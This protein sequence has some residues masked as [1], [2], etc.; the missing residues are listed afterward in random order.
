MTENLNTDKKS[1]G[2]KE[3]KRALDTGKAKTVYIAEDAEEKVVGNII[4][5]CNEGQIP[6][7]YVENMKKL[8]EVCKIDINAAVAVLLK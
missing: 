7:I 8:G 4:K 1:V 3:V 2:A 5:S 6:I